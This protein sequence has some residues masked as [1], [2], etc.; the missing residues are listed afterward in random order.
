VTLSRCI[1]APYDGFGVSLTNYDSWDGHLGRT[2]G[3]LTLLNGKSNSCEI[4]CILQ[5]A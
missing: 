3:I 1:L 2:D 4:L 5:I